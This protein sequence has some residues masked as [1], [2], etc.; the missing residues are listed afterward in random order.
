[1]AS[2]RSATNLPQIDESP[3]DLVLQGRLTSSHWPETWVT[4]DPR[5]GLRAYWDGCCPSA[6]AGWQRSSVPR[7]VSMKAMRRIRLAAVDHP[8]RECT[9]CGCLWL[10]VCWFCLC[11]V[12][13]VGGQAAPVWFVLLVWDVKWLV[14]WVFGV[15]SG[16]RSLFR[17]WRCLPLLRCLFV[18][19]GCCGG[20]GSASC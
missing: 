3:P 15:E 8:R 7:L 18:A 17:V 12:S 9:T 4:C 14:I 2:T 6:L 10:W 13:G 11:C 1:M 16:R 20:G 19:V 5:Q